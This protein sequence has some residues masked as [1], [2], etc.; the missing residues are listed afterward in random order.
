MSALLLSSLLL[1]ATAKTG[2]IAAP[3]PAKP[4][5]TSTVQIYRCTDAKG[6]VSL[7]DSPCP[8]GQN[9]TQREMVRPQDAPPKP[10]IAA[11]DDKPKPNEK[12]VVVIQER[13]PWSEPPPL[14]QCTDLD[15]KQ[16]DSETEDS[17]PR[18]VPLAVLGYDMRNAP[19]HLRDACQWVQD[20]C[21]RYRKSQLCDRWEIKRIEAQRAERTAGWSELKYRRSELKRIEQVLDDGCR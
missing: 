16:R 9:Q 1:M 6:K 7:R 19:Y 15:G 17:R 12:P 11:R 14:W 8:A 5:S 10:A 4:G 13:T 18:C 3:A 20:S 2:Q 21:V